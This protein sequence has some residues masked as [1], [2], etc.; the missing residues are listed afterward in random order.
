MI[1]LIKSIINRFVI[2]NTQHVACVSLSDHSKHSITPHPSHCDNL[3]KMDVRARASM[4]AQATSSG[5]RSA[6]SIAAAAAAP[7][8]RLAVGSAAARRTMRP[9]CNGGKKGR[10]LCMRVAAERREYYDFQDMPPLPVTVRR[11]HSHG[12][13]RSRYATVTVKVHHGHGHDAPRSRR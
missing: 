6:S 1:S 10:A 2:G 11:G 4:H 5:R 12:A 9:A 8:T 7:R 13:S 3:T